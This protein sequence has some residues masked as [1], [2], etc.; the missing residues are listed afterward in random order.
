[1][2]LMDRFNSPAHLPL[3]RTPGIDSFDPAPGEFDQFNDSHI[4]DACGMALA[5]S[6][7]ALLISYEQLVFLKDQSVERKA[8]FLDALQPELKALYKA[9]KQEWEAA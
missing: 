7:Q 9:V 8:A 3:P 6:I 5:P 4:K 1:M 2:E